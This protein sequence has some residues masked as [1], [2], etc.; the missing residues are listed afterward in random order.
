MAQ[1]ST[2][3]STRSSDRSRAPSAWRSPRLSPIDLF[4]TA[5]ASELRSYSS[6]PSAPRLREPEAAIRHLADHESYPLLKVLH[7]EI[8]SKAAVGPAETTVPGWA[9][10]LVNV[11][12]SQFVS[13]LQPLS[14]FGA[15][16]SD[17]GALGFDLAQPLRIPSRQSGTS[18][19]GSF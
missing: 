10:E 5:L 4:W 12:T 3:S 9:S 16:F 19:G 15:L 18:L 17:G 2:I 7:T 14:L 8:T 6:W 1:A 13:A 11:A